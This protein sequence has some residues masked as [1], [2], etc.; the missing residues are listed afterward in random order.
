MRPDEDTWDQDPA[1]NGNLTEYQL[2]NP[3]TPA[4]NILKVKIN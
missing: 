2:Q 1:C 4:H 3:S